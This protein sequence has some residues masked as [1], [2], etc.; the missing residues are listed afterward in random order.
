MEISAIG[1]LL[2]LLLLALPLY[3]MLAFDLRL[4]RRFCMSLVRMVA[5]VA[6]VAVAISLLLRYD[7]VWLDIVVGVVLALLSS[8]I[9]VIKS[10]LRQ[11]RLLVPV[12]AGSIVPLFV[13]TL[14]VLLFVLSIKTP[15][16]ARF[17]IPL[18]GLM[19]GLASGL[20][21]HALRTYYM[22]LEHH[23]ELYYYLLGNGATHRE[24]V[25]HFMRRGFQ[26]GM[27][28]ALKRMS[29]L[30]VT[31]AP[32]LMLGLVLSG[33]GVWTAAFFEVVMTIAVICYAL[34]TFWLAVL[35]SRRYVFD[36][37]EHLRPM[38]RRDVS[39]VP[40]SQPTPDEAAETIDI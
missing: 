29:G 40:V 31:G 6:V 25:R 20:V 17:F 2:G 12:M 23:N 36:E 5:V 16:A 24:A 38:K 28:T 34:S 26:A 21:A 30:F 27:L 15:F 11:R 8:V 13:L 10:G 32:V 14:Y 18:L 19:V 39:E 9:V 35:L 1:F 3:I 37:Y 33:V 7:K 22:G 4:L